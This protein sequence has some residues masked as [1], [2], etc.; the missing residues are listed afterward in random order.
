M[1]IR[2]GKV[3]RNLQ[4]QVEKNKED[5]EELQQQEPGVIYTA[6]DGI[7]ITED[8]ISVDNTVALK[9]ELFSGDYDDLTDKP[10]L[11]V[12]ATKTELNGYIPNNDTNYASTFR[13]KGVYVKESG[14]YTAT[15]YGDG[16]IGRSIPNQPG[17]TYTLPDKSGT[18]AMTSDIPSTSN[19]V[20]LD[21]FQ[22][23]TGYKIFTN[24]ISVSD[25]NNQYTCGI[26]PHG[27]G[28]GTTENGTYTDFS[29][30]NEGYFKYFKRLE[31]DQSTIVYNEYQLP[32]LDGTGSNT[33]TLA[34]TADIPSIS[35]LTMYNYK[36]T[37]GGLD[38]STSTARSAVYIIT[39]PYQWDYS[40]LTKYDIIRL[41]PVYSIVAD[42]ATSGNKGVGVFSWQTGTIAQIRWTDGTY[43]YMDFT[44][45][46]DATVTA[47]SPA[48]W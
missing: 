43:T 8:V 4:E 27:A 29:M 21:G 42:S 36:I 28:F 39:L 15:S 25:T 46:W 30:I 9:S 16:A 41:V 33:Y 3:Y 11:T 31:S 26:G 13:G 7:D 35:G 44:G 10:D 34:T 23:I 47:A 40:S 24:S 1:I 22:T 17:Y 14:T 45:S 32:H 6:G 5:I 37:I 18:F 2:N 48:H 19:F 12:Y 38:S 20:T